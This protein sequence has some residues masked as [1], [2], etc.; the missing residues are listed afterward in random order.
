MASFKKYNSTTGEWEYINSNNAYVADYTGTLSHS[1][2]T[3]AEAPYTKA[4][5]VN[6]IL[7]TDK[8]IMDMVCTGTYATDEAMQEDWAKIYRV[9]TSTNTL[10]FYAKEVPS[11]DINFI[12]RCVR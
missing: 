10:T 2:W 6:G 4:V 8:P 12:A 3:G 1:S 5:T 7:A 9:V 11:A